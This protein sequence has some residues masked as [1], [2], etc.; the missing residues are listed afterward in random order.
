MGRGEGCRAGSCEAHSL[1][2]RS[3]DSRHRRPCRHN[4]LGRPTSAPTHRGEPALQQGAGH[5]QV[6]GPAAGEEAG[7]KGSNAAATACQQQSAVCYQAVLAHVA[8]T[9]DGPA[10]CRQAGWLDSNQPRMHSCLRAASPAHAH[11][12]GGGLEADRAGRLGGAQRGHGGHA[13]LVGAPAQVRRRRE[14]S[15][16]GQEA[17]GADLPGGRLPPFDRSGARRKAGG[18]RANA[19]RSHCACPSRALPWRL[20]M[21]P[22]PGRLCSGSEQPAAGDRNERPHSLGQGRHRRQAG[23]A[24]LGG[25]AG[26][27]Q[28][29]EQERRAKHVE[30][31]G[32]KHNPKQ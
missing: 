6:G 2:G 4:T 15:W 19:P 27:R 32:L 5:G 18:G 7:S 11:S 17:Q 25:G 9:R 20:Y 29:G 3:A 26:A 31:G 16:S 13:S 23:P 12:L 28:H 22:S 1:P 30:I 8:M 24:L 10:G 21:P 14:S